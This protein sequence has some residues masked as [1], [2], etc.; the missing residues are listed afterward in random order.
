MLLTIIEVKRKDDAYGSQGQGLAL[1]GAPED[2]M[3]GMVC[4]TL[5]RLGLSPHPHERLAGQGERA[6]KRP[7]HEF[8]QRV[9][10]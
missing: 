4:Q 9:S 6:R 3:P 2:A 5:W 1:F 8:H 10:W 7:A